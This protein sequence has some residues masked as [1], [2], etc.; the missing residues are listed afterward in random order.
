MLII[1]VQVLRTILTKSHD[2]RGRLQ[3]INPYSNYIDPLK[4]PVSLSQ[5]SPSRT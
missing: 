5:D 4:G 1:T 3:T 2:P